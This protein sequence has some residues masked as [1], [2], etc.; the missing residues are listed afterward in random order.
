MGT[1]NHSSHHTFHHHRQ[2]QLLTHFRPQHQYHAMNQLSRHQHASAHHPTSNHHHQHAHQLTQ[3]H[4]HPSPF[5]KR[6]M[7]FREQNTRTRFKNNAL[8]KKKRRKSVLLYLQ[9]SAN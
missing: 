6:L 9:S 1:Q 8:G 7:T 2:H 5:A 4:Q 3:A